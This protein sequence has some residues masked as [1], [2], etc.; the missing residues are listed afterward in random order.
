LW[1]AHRGGEPLASTLIVP[2]RGHTAM[3]FT[4]PLETWEGIPTLAQLVARA[5]RAQDAAR[6][7][8][9]Q[10]LLEPQQQLE[11]QALLDAGFSDLAHLLYMQRRAPRQRPSLHLDGIEHVHWSEAHRDLFAN[12][13]LQ[14]YQD[15]M[16]CPGL[17]GLRQIDDIIAGHMATGE[18]FPQLWFALHQHGKPV[19]AMLLNRIPQ[20]QALE[21]VYLGLVPAWRGKGLARK[22]LEHGMGLARP[23]DADNVLLAVDENNT[24]ALNLYKSM[25]FSIN[26]RKLAMVFA[27]QK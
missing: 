5:G 27:L 7:R 24:P 1:V 8:L 10:A 11:Q 4:S 12:A 16:D 20:Q 6:V 23:H 17:L 13:I 22:M 2:N 26:G 9:L 15:T 3:V 14:T 25:R 21:L 19:G 18:F